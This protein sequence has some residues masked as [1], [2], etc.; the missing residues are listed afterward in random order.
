MSE[1]TSFRGGG[2]CTGEDL[3]RRGHFGRAH[4]LQLLP[5]QPLGVQ[6]FVK[7]PVDFRR[8][9]GCFGYWKL[10]SVSLESRVWVWL[11]CVRLRGHLLFACL[12][13]G[14]WL[15]V[16]T[17]RDSL[18]AFSSACAPSPRTPRT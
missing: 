11:W 9:C 3:L 5:G 14:G 12:S 16:V 10:C 17:I 7:V 8:I 13:Q 1:L 18:G 2:E 4:S 15:K 6:V